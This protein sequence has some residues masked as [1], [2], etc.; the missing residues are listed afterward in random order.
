[1]KF[2]LTDVE[3]TKI[4]EWEDSHECS[5]RTSDHGMKNERY[6]GAIGGA[7]TYSFTPTGLGT[8]LV[9]SCTCGKELNLTPFE[10][11]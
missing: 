4:A 8:I 3:E 11:W 7:T 6:V 9:V 2:Y 5:L 1:M 10:E